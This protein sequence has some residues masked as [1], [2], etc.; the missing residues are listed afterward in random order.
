[1]VEFTLP[2]QQPVDSEKLCFEVFC[3]FLILITEAGITYN[4][5]ELIIIEKG[6]M[7]INQHRN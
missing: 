2:W 7:S 5:N 3:G 4:T 6:S 1:M